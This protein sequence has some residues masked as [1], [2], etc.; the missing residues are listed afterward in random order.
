MR[1]SIV[2]CGESSGSYLLEYANLS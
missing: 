1:I 2:D